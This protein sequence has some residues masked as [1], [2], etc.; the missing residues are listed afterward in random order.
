M[1]SNGYVIEGGFVSGWDKDFAHPTRPW[2]LKLSETDDFMQHE[3]WITIQSIMEEIFFKTEQP[4][5]LEYLI[6][7]LAGLCWE[8][9]LRCAR[10][11]VH[12]HFKKQGIVGMYQTAWWL[13][14]HAR[15]L[16]IAVDPDHNINL[17]TIASPSNPL[18]NR[19]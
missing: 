5:M 3:E 13:R 10:D 12:A 9:V 6:G 16:P 17:E 8:N 19:H 18:G 7:S 15:G 14:L 1:S 4:I 11:A 2:T